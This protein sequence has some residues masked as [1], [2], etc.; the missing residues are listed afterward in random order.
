[1]LVVVD[2]SMMLSSLWPLIMA[3]VITNNTVNTSNITTIVN[4]GSNMPTAA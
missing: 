2:G 4:R 1:M 3:I